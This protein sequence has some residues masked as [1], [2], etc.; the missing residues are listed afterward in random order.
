M[1]Q[2]YNVPTGFENVALDLGLTPQ[3]GGQFVETFIGTT[4]RANHEAMDR[5]FAEVTAKIE[6]ATLASRSK[7]GRNSSCVCGSGRKFKKCCIG[8]ARFTG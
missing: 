5:R 6:G 7:I 2:A 8:K 4:A 1:A 3:P